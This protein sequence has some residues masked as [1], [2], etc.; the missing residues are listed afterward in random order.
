MKI[1]QLCSWAL[2]HI[3]KSVKKRVLVVLST[4]S[5]LYVIIRWKLMCIDIHSQIRIQNI[6]NSYSV[7]ISAGSLCQDI[8]KADEPSIISCHT[9]YQETGSAFSGNWLNQSVVFKK[10]PVVDDLTQFDATGRTI[11]PSEEVFSQMVK[12]TVKFKFNISIDDT[13]ALK[14]SHLQKTQGK[15]LRKIEMKNVWSLLQDNEY[16]ALLL[17]EKYD[18]FP[19]L[20]GTCGEMY[21]IQKMESISGYWH[22]MTLYDSAEEWDRRIK[23]ALMIL[24]YLILLEERLPEPMHMCGVKMGHFGFKSDSKKIIY[25]HIDAVHPRSVVNRITGSKSE[26]KQHSDCDYL[27][28]RSFCNLISQK[29]DHGVVNNNL[30]I[31]CERIFL[32]WVIS[33]RVMVPGL[34]LG[35]RSP[36]VLIELLD[37]CANPE[38]APGTPRASATKEIRKR[39]YDLLSNLKLY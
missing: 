21:A 37:L 31:V 12:N 1:K 23:T 3:V 29:C 15:V 13:D 30:Q 7:G 18:V 34:L 17:Y 20:L 16:L 11:F 36:K 39:L 4:L 5:I 32:G 33:G 6:C 10:V 2:V 8:C 28:C 14:I 19:K 22:L 27:D 35:P 25:Q 9:F 26:C 24:E 38:R